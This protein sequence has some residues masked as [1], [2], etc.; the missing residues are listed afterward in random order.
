[1]LAVYRVGFCCGGRQKKAEVICC[2][3]QDSKARRRTARKGEPKRSVQWLVFE[4]N[5]QPW[6]SHNIFT[7]RAGSPSPRRQRAR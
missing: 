4:Q 2:E 5:E 6:D 1:M 7:L 3:T